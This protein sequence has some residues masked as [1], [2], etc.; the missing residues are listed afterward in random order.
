MLVAEALDL[1]DASRLPKTPAGRHFLLLLVRPSRLSVLHSTC[2]QADIHLEAIQVVLPRVPV[3]SW[4]SKGTVHGQAWCVGAESA[5]GLHCCLM[6]N[7]QLSRAAQILPPLSVCPWSS[8]S[9]CEVGWQLRQ[10]AV[11]QFSCLPFKTCCA[12]R[13]GTGRY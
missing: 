8:S 4:S 7:W 1:R 10:H 13:I 11:S 12:A 3:T 6:S 5:T 2:M 9:T